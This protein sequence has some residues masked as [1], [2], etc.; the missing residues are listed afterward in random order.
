MHIGGRPLC[1]EQQRLVRT[2][3]RLHCRHPHAH[4]REALAWEDRH[5]LC[6]AT[7]FYVETRHLFDPAISAAEHPFSL[8]EARGQLSATDVGGAM[9]RVI[10]RAVFLPRSR[11][12]SA[13]EEQP[14]TVGCAAAGALTP[15]DAPS[16]QVACRLCAASLPVRVAW[17][18]HVRSITLIVLCGPSPP[19]H[20]LQQQVQCPP[21][22][23][24]RSQ[25]HSLRAPSCPHCSAATH[26]GHC[27]AQQLVPRNS[28][29][30]ERACLPA[31]KGALHGMR[32]CPTPALTASWRGRAVWVRHTAGALSRHSVPRW[33]HMFV[34]ARTTPPTSTSDAG[35]GACATGARA[36][37]TDA[38]H[39]PTCIEL[40][41]RCDE[42][43]FAAGD[44]AG[45]PVH[46]AAPR[47][48]AAVLCA[49][50]GRLYE[51]LQRCS[52][53]WCVPCAGA[54]DAA[55]GADSAATAVALAWQGHGVLAA[56]VHADVLVA[57][58]MD[59]G[60]DAGSALRIAA[61]A[62]AQ[63]PAECT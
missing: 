58:L 16:W 47:D 60:V 40:G 38:W 23:R 22:T 33:H 14:G 34:R 45:G 24:G 20:V 12:T 56:A 41:D 4:G 53:R 2:R 46:P 39:P 48:V 25:A 50:Y 30:G 15:A 37:A 6:R 27:A 5:L 55:P 44:P 49:N 51:A 42:V 62:A 7:S 9:V 43:P 36:A 63:A 29:V 61:A 59:G 1:C 18:A 11:I 28:S 26:T 19:A 32:R 52:A 57:C 35:A 54:D 17:A 10:E 8:P 21:P 3:P 31:L 13:A